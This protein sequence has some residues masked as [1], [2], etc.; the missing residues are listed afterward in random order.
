MRP[1]LPAA[2]AGKSEPSMQHSSG[3]TAPLR[4]SPALTSAARQQESHLEGRQHSQALLLQRDQVTVAQRV[5]FHHRSPLDGREAQGLLH[6]RAVRSRSQPRKQDRELPALRQRLL[7][8][9]PHRQLQMADLARSARRGAAHQ[10]GC[11]LF[12]RPL[13]PLERPVEEGRVVQ[14]QACKAHDLS[15]VAEGARAPRQS[16]KQ[17]RTGIQ[18]V[19]LPTHALHSVR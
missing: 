1:S 11:S 12:L 6:S 4:G 14:R 9:R 10:D 7:K 19:A 3:C 13:N 17:V 15:P 5:D 8:A 18:R 2:A 16:A